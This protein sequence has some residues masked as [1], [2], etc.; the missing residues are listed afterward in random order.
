MKRLIVCATVLLCGVVQ[1]R[2]EPVFWEESGHY[3][4]VIFPGEMTWHEAR[5]HAESLTYATGAG[6]LVAITSR[7]ENLWLSETFA[8]TLGSHYPLIGA[9]QEE[10]TNPAAGWHWVTDE[11]W[12]Y[13]NW[14][15]GEPNDSG[16]GEDI[17]MFWGSI[18]ED[19]VQ[20]N[21]GE[22]TTPI[23]SYVIEYDTPDNI[24]VRTYSETLS[25]VVHPGGIVELIY[26][27]TP[28]TPVSDALWEV[29]WWKA[30][31]GG[32]SGLKYY[33][34]DAT[35]SYSMPPPYASVCISQIPISQ[36]AI[37][38]IAED[39]EIVIELYDSISIRWI[40]D[41]ATL[42]YDYVVVVPEPSSLVLLI[43]GAVSLLAYGW[44]RRK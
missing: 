13:T 24:E 15:F 19:G 39:G 14:A 5:G 42:S 34:E 32:G 29:T 7:E 28:G 20:W 27:D 30:G 18:G 12:E 31:Y 23:D 4:D 9:Y 36:D 37:A 38:S 1:V 43:V 41:S 35:G 3:Y 17:G 44:R 22:G 8:D 33:I 6:H 21:D 26:P 10:S 2:A 40:I 11:P 16:N 25:G